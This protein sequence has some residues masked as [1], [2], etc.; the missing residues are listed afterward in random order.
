MLL[1]QR[2]VA[3]RRDAQHQ[4]EAALDEVVGPAERD[5][6]QDQRHAQ[7]RLQLGEGDGGVGDMRGAERFRRRHL[8][9]ADRLG[10][11]AADGAFAALDLAQDPLAE[12]EIG[13]ALVG[14]IERAGRAVEEP[15]AEPRL[16][17]AD[18]ARHQRAREAEL[19]GGDGEAARAHHPDEA[20]HRAE[21]VHRAIATVRLFNDLQQY[22]A[23]LAASAIKC[24]SL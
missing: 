22:R 12:F 17:V 9:R 11:G 15:H 1:D 20:L 19:V 14:Q 6:L 3:Q 24:Q 5:V 21:A 18:V 13:A 7:S 23:H 10:A 8:E 16:Q 4:I 2:G